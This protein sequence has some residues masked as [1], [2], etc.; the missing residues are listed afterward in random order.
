MPRYAA[1]DIGS[2]SIRLQVAETIP[3]APPRIL[4]ADREVTRLGE[5]VF[6]SGLLSEDSMQF[7]CGVLARMA[8][9]YQALEV[10]GVRAVATA[11][12]RDAR[13][14]AEFI[15]RA[16]AAAGA[17]VEVISG[18]EEARLIHLGVTSRWPEA[19]PNLL[20]VDIGGGSAELIS[21]HN[22]RMRDAISKPLGAI[23]LRE[24]F[25]EHDPPQ[26]SE[27]EQMGEYIDE[28][29]RPDLGRFQ[30]VEYTRAIATSAT[31]A[32]AV[33][34]VSGIPRARRDEADRRRATTAGIR[35]LFKRLASM[36]LAARRKVTGI[37]PRRAQIIVPGVCVLL[38]VLSALGLPAVYHS[39]AGVRD[40]IVA[41]LAAR[42][43]GR[44]LAQLKVEDRKEM[45]RMSVRYG[46]AR[47]HARQV[48]AFASQLFEALQPVHNLPAGLG[49]VLEA[50]AY[51]HDVGHFIADSSHHKHSYYIVANSDMP[52]FT[53]RE[54]EL[55]AN[56]CRY[57]R[58]A[59]PAA[60]HSNLRPLAP[61]DRQVLLR[62]IPLLRLADGLDRS[63]TQS[64]QRVNCA[65]INGEIGLELEYSA[66]IDLDLWAAERLS[67]LFLEVYGR[68][69]VV[70][71]R[72]VTAP[73][74]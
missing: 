18:R 16:S 63:H 65:V 29:L 3:G 62:L 46:V 21:S 11:S 14:Q 72:K 52:G 48:A 57:H 68:R 19:G 69:I 51:L 8:R 20:I 28:K 70:R 6:H 15:E 43:V 55:V 30:S 53:A 58:K 10:A 24:I 64:V 49:R 33:C 7:A 50:A 42:G 22:G 31:A 1:I 35:K 39:G 4:A 27:V 67:A 56:L 23:R 74:A 45:E 36:D 38:R 73:P 13:N 44:E 54:R 61:E 37:G 5:S 60:D 25:L 41:D 34:A 40:G 2:N 26:E 59:L 17:P 32:A 12:V 9:R 66:D 47:D 71:S